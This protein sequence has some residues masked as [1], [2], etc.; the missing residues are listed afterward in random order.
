[1]RKIVT[2]LIFGTLVAYVLYQ[3]FAAPTIRNRKLNRSIEV[4]F[5]GFWLKGKT[6]MWKKGPYRLTYSFGNHLDSV[7][8]LGTFVFSD[9]YDRR[10]TPKE[11]QSWRKNT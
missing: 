5:S 7:F 6:I 4:A 9:F 11:Q 8:F 1:M 3:Q 2:Y 10:R